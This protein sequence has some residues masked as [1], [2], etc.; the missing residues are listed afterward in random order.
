MNDKI[1]MDFVCIV[2]H[3]MLYINVGKSTSVHENAGV[4]IPL[5][6]KARRCKAHV[7]IPCVE[8]LT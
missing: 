6:S 7:R 3:F 2:I 5:K 8:D 1:Q 4:H